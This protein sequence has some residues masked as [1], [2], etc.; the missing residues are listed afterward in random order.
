LTRPITQSESAK[1]AEIWGYDDY[2]KFSPGAYYADLF[3]R[4]AQPKEGAR[5]LDVGAGSGAATVEL[6]KRGLQVR[7]FDLTSE[8]WRHDDIPLLTGTIWRDLPAG[9]FDYTYCCDV[10]EHIPTEYVGLS[11]DRILAVGNRGFF[12]ISFVQDHFGS[13]IGQPLHLTIKP[14]LWWVDLFSELGSLIDARDLIENG[15]FYVAR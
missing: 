6:K 11:I 1:Y 13:V 8:A 2:A 12:S 15:V 7:A 14:F 4:I 10:M 9:P 3:W 5:V